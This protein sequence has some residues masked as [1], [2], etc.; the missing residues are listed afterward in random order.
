M[1]GKELL[2][3]GFSQLQKALTTSY[4]LDAEPLD[5]TAI[6]SDDKTITAFLSLAGK[7]GTS[8]SRRMK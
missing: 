6:P 1:T 3:S 4:Q 2:L 8:S 5:T 7:L